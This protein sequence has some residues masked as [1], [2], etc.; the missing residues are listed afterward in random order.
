MKRKC[1]SGRK[2]GGMK[3]KSKEERE[4]KWVSRKKGKGARLRMKLIMDGY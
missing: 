4:G 2:T 1:A 3:E